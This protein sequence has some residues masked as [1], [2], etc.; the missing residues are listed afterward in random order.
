MNTRNK[1]KRLR[2]LISRRIGSGPTASELSSNKAVHQML[3][4]VIDQSPAPIKSVSI[5]NDTVRA[6]VSWS[7][8]AYGDLEGQI[9]SDKEALAHVVAEASS[10]VKPCPVP[11]Y[12]P[13]VR[14]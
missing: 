9:P 6:I 10:N 4:Q 13:C 1:A 8:I 2:R 11:L 7:A 3:E 12:P 5:E 14:P